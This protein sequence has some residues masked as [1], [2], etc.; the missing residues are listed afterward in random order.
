MISSTHRAVGALLVVTVIWGWT[1][2]FDENGDDSRRGGDPNQGA[3]VIAAFMAARFGMAACLMP[4][5]V[6]K[7]RAAIGQRFIWADGG[8]LA[9]VLMVGFLLQMFGLR[10]I[11]PA[12]SAF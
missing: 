4:L 6:S 9:A 12:V 10:G 1:S 5:F 3:I 2:S 11:D 8:L 7:A